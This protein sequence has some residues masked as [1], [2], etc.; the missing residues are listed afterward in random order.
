[1]ARYGHGVGTR[2]LDGILTEDLGAHRR[3]LVDHPL[4]TGL[5]DGRT[6][7]GHL[8]AFALQDA[9]LIREV[10]RLDGLAI[11]KAPDAASADVLIRK[12]V[13]KSGALDTLRCFG[14]AV[15]LAPGALDRVEPLPGC[16][17]LVAHFY[18]HLARSTFVETLAAIGASE[19]IFL[20]ICG[21]WEP[22][23]I[24]R[25]LSPD[26]LAFFT[27]HDRLE[28]AEIEA[29]ELIA[30]LVQGREAAEAVTAAVKLCYGLERL[31]YDTVLANPS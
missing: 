13:P 19:T 10:H 22:A 21:R 23:L 20:E 15:G 24:A 7:D 30:A 14:E 2:F 18:Y 6:T 27:L 29:T 9:W 25:G 28:A 3:A 12:L 5:A 4:W 17:G 26:A 8:R 31:F 1:M 11:A 16:A